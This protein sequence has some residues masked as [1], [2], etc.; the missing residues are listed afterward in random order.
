MIIPV[1]MAANHRSHAVELGDRVRSWG[2]TRGSGCLGWTGR[3][4]D[5]GEV[6]RV[7]EVAAAVV[8][9]L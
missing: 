6:L 1:A 2:H 3:E 8:G 5:R 7:P 4:C 9:M